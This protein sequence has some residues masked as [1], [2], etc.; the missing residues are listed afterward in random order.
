MTTLQSGIL[1]KKKWLGRWKKFHCELDNDSFK[2]YSFG[3]TR[4]K[5]LEIFI[6]SIQT[7]R[8][9]ISNIKLID[10]VLNDNRKYVFRSESIESSEN[11]VRKIRNAISQQSQTN[12][13]LVM[14][15]EN[16]SSS[17]EQD[18]TDE[19]YQADECSMNIS[20]DRDSDKP[21]TQFVFASNN[22]KIQLDLPNSK[23]Y[24]SRK[25]NELKR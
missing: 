2:V 19:S 21:L 8:Q 13:E 17:N 25:I 12:I 22:N 16:N 7:A 11:W 24:R 10:I 23:A 4:K 18:E 14:N 15:S 3:R 1:E 9:D 5:T 20:Y 6:N